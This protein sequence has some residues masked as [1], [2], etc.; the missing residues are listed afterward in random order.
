M[1][2]RSRW[3]LI[4]NHIFDPFF[5]PPAK[6]N[7]NGHVFVT[8]RFKCVLHLRNPKENEEK[9]PHLKNLQNLYLLAFPFPFPPKKMSVNSIPS[10]ARLPSGSDPSVQNTGAELRVLAAQKPRGMPGMPGK[11]PNTGLLWKDIRDSFKAPTTFH[12]PYL[13]VQKLSH[14]SQ[15]FKQIHCQVIQDSHPLTNIPQF[16]SCKLSMKLES[17]RCPVRG[18]KSIYDILG[19]ATST[20]TSRSQPA[21]VLSTVP[22]LQGQTRKVSLASCLDKLAVQCGVQRRDLFQ[23][24][25]KSAV[26]VGKRARVPS[27]FFHRAEAYKVWKKMNLS[28]SPTS[29]PPA[30]CLPFHFSP[31][32]TRSLETA[33]RSCFRDNRCPWHG[34]CWCHWIIKITSK[35]KQLKL[36]LE[37]LKRKKKSMNFHKNLALFGLWIFF[38]WLSIMI[39]IIQDQLFPR[40]LS[41]SPVWLGNILRAMPRDCPHT[42]CGSRCTS[43]MPQYLPRNIPISANFS[44]KTVWKLQPWQNNRKPENLRRFSMADLSLFRGTSNGNLD[45]YHADWLLVQR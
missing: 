9:R 6:W 15:V 1:I 29:Q 3:W 44:N 22:R 8:S 20:S 25:K 13:L 34:T 21:A 42:N 23:K 24:P 18:R 10:A 12:H 11:N 19:T 14:S 38:L 43:E 45:V 36:S 27:N 41:V 2:W 31:Q 17:V 26:Q 4:W 32:L 37:S 28:R 7:Q 5:S 39:G 16:L 40:T 35:N 33:Q 30:T